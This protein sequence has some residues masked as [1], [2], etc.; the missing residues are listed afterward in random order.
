M[1]SN[2][3]NTRT[4]KAVIGISPHG[5]GI[6]FSGIYPGSISDSEITEKSGTILFVEKEHERMSDRGFSIQ[7]FCAIKG[8]SLNRPKQKECDQ[9]AQVDVAKNFDITST[10]IHVERFIGRIRD[11]GNYKHCLANKSDRHF[12][13]KFANAM[14]H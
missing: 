11:W 10:R 8:V 4:G 6:L 13:I 9:F 12:I 1:F 3:K 5:S 7:D 2:Y 14:T